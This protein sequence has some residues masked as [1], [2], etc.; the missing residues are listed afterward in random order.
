MNRTKK[1]AI[2]IFTGLI[3][4]LIGV[5]GTLL[6]PALV[7]LLGT[8]RR[9]AHGTSLAIILPISLVSIVIY[10]K[11]GAMPFEAGLLISAGGL[12]GGYLGARL[13]RRIS[14]LWLKRL[15]SIFMIIAGIR[16]IW[17]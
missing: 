3:N 15:F 14:Q 4:G 5:G 10:S 13:L 1:L 16:M 17:P 2:G 7:H 12:F 11:S 9:M 6:V 8:E